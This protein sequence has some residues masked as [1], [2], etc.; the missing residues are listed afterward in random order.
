MSFLSRHDIDNR[1]KELYSLHIMDTDIEYEF[2]SLVKITS[3]LL[4]CPIALI[5]LLDD[6]RQWFKA[7]I[8]LNVRETPIEYAFCNTAIQKDEVFTVENAL[9]DERFKSNPL[10]VGEP[11]IRF[12]SGYP[13]KTKNNINIGTLCVIDSKPKT[14]SEKDKKLL[15][16]LGQQALSLIEK[17]KLSKDIQLYKS[18]LSKSMDKS[19][20]QKMGT[21]GFNDEINNLILPDFMF[22]RIKEFDGGFSLDSIASLKEIL[23]NLC[24]ILPKW[25]DGDNVQIHS[26]FVLGDEATEVVFVVSKVKKGEISGIA[27]ELDGNYLLDGSSDNDIFS[28]LQIFNGLEANVSLVNERGYLEWVNSKWIK[29]TLENDGEVEYTGVGSNYLM[30]CEN[31]EGEGSLEAKNMAVGMKRILSGEI[32]SFQQKYPCHSPLEKRYYLA[33]LSG[34]SLRGKKYVLIVHENV[35]DNVIL[36][37]RERHAKMI[38]E[39]RSDLIKEIHHRVKN[40]LQIVKSL[41]ALQQSEFSDGNIKL[42]LETAARRVNTIAL[43]HEKLYSNDD[44]ANVGIDEYITDLFDL[45]LSESHINMSKSLSIIDLDVPIEKA[46]PMG[47]IISELVSNSIKYA[48]T[49]IKNPEITIAL[50]KSGDHYELTYQDNGN[51]YDVDKSAKGLGSKLIKS[52]ASQLKA[53]QQIT[54]SKKGT[55][56]KLLNLRF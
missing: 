45:L 27:Y 15:Q 36:Q 24:D 8:G 14:F 28:S 12:Y 32:N 7:L 50:E 2:Q 49:G 35:T 9:L 46:N 41:I 42:A 5:S 6:K 38:A 19:E 1:V 31:A 33:L 34:F 29:F 39:Q 17:H 18:F 53:T 47:M 30:I 44:L 10:V 26:R 25:Q 20:S 52:L 55:E 56:F 13:L 4:N 11:N 23:P 51:G 3:E 43:I 48:F 40:N 16:N 21:W 37:E 22:D 54:S